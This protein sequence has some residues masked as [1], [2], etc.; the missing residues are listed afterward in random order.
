ML[1]AVS[2]PV[3]QLSLSPVYGSIP[4]SAYHSHITT[5]AIILPWVARQRLPNHLPNRIINCLPVLAFLLPTIQSMLFKYSKQLGPVY[6]PVVTELL[7]CFPL[8]FISVLGVTIYLNDFAW[9][10]KAGD[11]LP[12]IASYGLFTIVQKASRHFIDRN[13]GSSIIFTRSGLQFVVATFYAL[14]LPSKFV[15][16]AV[17]PILYSAV[18]N[19]HI[20]LQHNVDVLNSTLQVNGYSILARQ[21]S[22]TGYISVLDNVKDGFRV[23]RCD[24]SLLGGEW[25]HHQYKSVSK[26][27]EPIYAIFVMLEAV[28][29]VEPATSKP[30]AMIPDVEKNALVMWEPLI[31]SEVEL[32]L[33]I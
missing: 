24:H 11:T 16:F 32:L 12:A 10:Q 3:S 18:Y 25:L 26:L 6:G 29:L 23:L 7:T 5:A 17:L 30:H 22:L 2:S 33:M 15:I 20:P 27:G 13:V 4:S 9:R 31:P 8:V 21:E 1:A 19:P 28:R 14:L